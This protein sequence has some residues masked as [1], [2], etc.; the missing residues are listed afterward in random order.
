[1]QTELAETL[2]AIARAGARAFYEG[3][4][5]DKLAAAVQAAGG[6]MT[7]KDL[8]HYHPSSARRSSAAIA[9]TRSSRCRRR[10]REASF[11]SKC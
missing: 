3:A 9:I 11:S 6:V 7:S 4:I 2:A 5:A 10:H 1:V 8:A